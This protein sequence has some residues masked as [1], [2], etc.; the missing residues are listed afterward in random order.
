MGSHA[1]VQLPM[2]LVSC[3]G[4]SPPSLS[5]QKGNSKNCF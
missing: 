3:M 2:R 4:R 5:L 1:L